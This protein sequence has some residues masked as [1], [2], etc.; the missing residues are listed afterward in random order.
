MKYKI[1]ILSHIC[2]KTGRNGCAYVTVMAILIIFPLILQT[3]IN[4]LLEDRSGRGR[5]SSTV[6]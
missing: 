3:V 5:G 6:I 4:V 2:K 1:S